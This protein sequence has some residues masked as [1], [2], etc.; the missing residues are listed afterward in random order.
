MIEYNISIDQNG[1]AVEKNFSYLSINAPKYSN[2]AI[3]RMKQ[4][5][6]KLTEEGFFTPWISK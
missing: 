3:E 1:K 4:V 2:P 6:E 5:V